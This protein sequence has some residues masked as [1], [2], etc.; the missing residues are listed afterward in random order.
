MRKTNLIGLLILVLY[1]ACHGQN[2]TQPADQDWQ[3][4]TEN[5]YTISYPT[6]WSLDQSG[7]MGTSFILLSPLSSSEDKFRENV[8]LIVQDISAYDLDLDQ[9]VKISEDQVKTMITNANILLSERVEQNGSAFHKVVYTGQ[10]G[11]FDL[12]FEQYYWVEGKEAYVLTFT[13]QVDQFDAY[14]PTGE[15]VLDSFR[16]K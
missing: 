7:Q 8:N 1:G 5:G 16:T 11:A 10:Q 13:A 6:E 14:Q 12:K 4:L 9:Y 2:T 3:S 15:R